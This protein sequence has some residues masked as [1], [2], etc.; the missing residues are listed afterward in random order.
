MNILNI[1]IVLE[2][3]AL[4]VPEKIFINEGQQYH[5][6]QD[7]EAQACRLA[8]VLT[9]LG[10]GY[11]DKVALLMPNSA[12]FAICQYGALKL[13]AVVVPLSIK[14]PGTEIAYFLQDSQAVALVA[15]SSVVVA[16]LE[17]FAK[18]DTCRDLLIVNSSDSSDDNYTQL[19]V[20]LLA[21]L[22][23]DAATNFET[24]ST[25]PETPALILYTSGTTGNPKG[26]LLT[27][28][29]IYSLAQ[30]FARD[31]C[32][33]NSE[34]VVLMVPPA[35]HMFGQLLMN[36]ACLAQAK[37]ILM[38]SFNPQLFLSTIEQEKVTFFAGV[39][40]VA[41][42]LLNTPSVE[43]YDTSSWRLMM[44]GA[45]TLHP[46]VAE[47][48][49]S[50]FQVNLCIAYG[51]TEA[52]P[53]TFAHMNANTPDGT[54]GKATSGNQ[55]KIVDTENQELPLGTPGEILL[56]S[57]H[58]F[59]EYY[60]LPEQ[61]LAA[62]EGNWFRTGDIGYLDQ[63]G[64]LFIVDRSKDAIKTSGYL[65]FPAEVERVL[66]THPKVAEAAVVGI[67]HESL[68]EVIKAFVV[69]K[70][71]AITSSREL[72]NYCKEHLSRY[73]CPRQIIFRDDLPQGSSGKI[74]RR[75]LRT[76]TQT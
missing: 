51:L 57:P 53:V 44:F 12:F 36:M 16:A 43:Q 60:N 62:F 27:H 24:V 71:E 65:V 49:R 47:R 35:S 64:Y 32:G 9:G 5:T 69:L 45:A 46:E 11:G 75:V 38:S 72:I 73:K 76:N 42:L 33:I 37:L 14:A 23:N 22:M 21:E 63:N 7:I 55:L 25:T 59:K 6:F 67:P 19:G 58:L 18:I 74:L 15:C 20:K 2:D 3:S 28:Y 56:R 34:D 29:N 1:S 66:Y 17:G 41:T 61:S 8:N 39:P 52:L 13:G 31:L 68:G 70:N 4:R 54:V 48:F 30:S 50:R 26:V 10:I 40:R